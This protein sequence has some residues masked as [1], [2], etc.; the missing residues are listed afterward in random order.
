M[1]YTLPMAE[2]HFEEEKQK[3]CLAKR[4]YKSEAQAIMQA[5]ITARRTGT[6]SRAYKCIFCRG[7]HL[8]TSPSRP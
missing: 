7:W 8:T 5:E 1:W 4:R 2:T 3:S 6:E